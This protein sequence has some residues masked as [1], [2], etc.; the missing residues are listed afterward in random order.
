MQTLLWCNYSC[1]SYSQNKIW[2]L[3][4]HENAES[5]SFQ[6]CFGD[7][8]HVE[9]YTHVGLRNCGEIKNLNKSWWNTVYKKPWS[10]TLL[11]TARCILI[12]SF[13]LRL[14]RKLKRQI[15]L[16]YNCKLLKCF[17]WVCVVYADTAFIPYRYYMSL[18]YS[19]IMKIVNGQRLLYCWFTNKMIA[20][21][22][23]AGKGVKNTFLYLKS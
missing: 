6:D 16:I 11:Y 22:L 9:S 19:H 13:K 10:S 18:P 3:T 14:L 7:D 2:K 12:N 17:I 1:I 4:T 8:K 5:L 20:N 21:R 15:C 23:L